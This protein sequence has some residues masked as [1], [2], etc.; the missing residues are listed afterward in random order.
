M[1][2]WRIDYWNNPRAGTKRFFT[3]RGMIRWINANIYSDWYFTID[4]YKRGKHVKKL[5]NIGLGI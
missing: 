3:Q 1:R 5:S 2:K 4:I